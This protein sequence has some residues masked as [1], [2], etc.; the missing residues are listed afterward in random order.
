MDGKYIGVRM[1]QIMEEKGLRPRDFFSKSG[2][3]EKLDIKK[4]TR[5]N[6]YNYFS[7][8]IKKPSLEYIEL[9]CMISGVSIHYFF[10]EDIPEFVVTEDEKETIIEIRQLTRPMQLHLR[11]YIKM[12]MKEDGD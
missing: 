11:N 10:Q 9:F 8:N 3:A 5:S 7:G 6:F 12:L 2:I 4:F 1:H